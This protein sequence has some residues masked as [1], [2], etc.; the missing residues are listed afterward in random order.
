LAEVEAV[1]DEYRNQAE[2]VIVYIKEAHPED[3]WQLE[4]N[5]TG[6]VVYTQPKT[7]AARL[8][9][10][11]KFVEQM[12]VETP[13]LVDDIQNTAMA[14]YAAWPERLYIIETDGTIAYKGDMGPS[15]F[16]PDEVKEYLDERFAR[17]ATNH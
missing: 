10:V 16:R 9:L 13:T 6:N 15:G 3:E 1:R 14:C 12:G 2:F 17:G 11:S 8:D 5:R 7:F 4:S